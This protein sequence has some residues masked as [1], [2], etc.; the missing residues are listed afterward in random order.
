[1]P[2]G[3]D[4][5]V[6]FGKTTVSDAKALELT[7]WGGIGQTAMRQSHHIDIKNNN[8]DYFFKLPQKVVEH[9]DLEVRATIDSGTGEVSVNYD[10]VLV[11]N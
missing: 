1:M 4:A 7:F 5:Y 6:V 9:T 10:I 11:A 2:D 3:Y 8:Y